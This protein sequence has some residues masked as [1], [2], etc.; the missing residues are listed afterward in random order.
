MAPPAPEVVTLG[1]ALV[2]LLAADGLPL[3][4]ARQYERW[5][6]GAESN[7]AV[8][9]SRLGHSVA[10]CGRVGHDAFGD[11]VRR[12][13]REEGIDTARLRTDTE[14]RTGVM[15]RDCPVGRAIEV[16]YHRE[17]SAGSR[18]CPEDVPLE[19]VRAAGCLYVSGITAML[20]PSANAAVTAAVR[21]AIEGGTPVLFDPNVRLKLGPPERWRTI[22]RPLVESA[23]TVLLGGDEM[24]LLTE[25][26]GTGWLLDRG[27]QMVVVKEGARGAWATDGTSTWRAE[28][29]QV[30][31]VD[32]VGA[33]DAFTAGWLSAQLRGL[34]VS[35]RLV[36]ATTVAACVVAARGDVAGLPSAQVRDHLM[37]ADSDVIR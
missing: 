16:I 23:A 7:V 37:H 25:G 30:S 21:A 14:A 35:D 28:A 34:D 22:L 12:F 9:V 29:R 13:L 11:A 26:G 27:P 24:E 5:V 17:G 32:P 31:A 36:E 3:V 8:G 1:E 4:H 18:L 2:V 33:G 19:T 10:F 6:V 15:V 20:S